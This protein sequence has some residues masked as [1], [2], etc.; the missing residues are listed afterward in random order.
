MALPERIGKYPVLRE[1]GAGA[2]S[3]VY[4]AR[5]PFAG[6]EVAIKVFLFDKHADEHEERMMHKAFVAEA[7][8]AGK[9]NHP[10]IVDIFDAVVDPDRSYLVMEYVAGT[11]L[12]AH[13]EAP[14]LLP[15]GKV[16]EII[17][18]CV[19]ALE[20]A[21]RHGVIHRD[22][23]PGN[24]L[25]SASGETK[26]G[27]FGASFQQKLLDTTQVSLVGSPAYMS[28]EQIRMEPLT[29]QTDIYSLGVTMYRLVTGRLP[30]AA[31]TQA[32]LTYAI[33]NAEP[34]RP[35]QLRPEL[36]ALLDSVVMRAIAKDPAARYASW[37][38]FGRDLSQAFAALRQA[39]GVLSD[40]ERF[41][42]LR[43][44]PF[45]ADFNDVAL[46]E[47]VRIGAWK[48]IAAGSVVLREGEPGD[49][50]Y[51]LADGEVDVTLSG[52]LL[53]TVKAGRCFG[54]ML[55]FSEHEQPRSTTVSAR[56]DI[57]V[58]EVKAAAMR[59]A[60]DACQA[61]LNRACMRVLIERLAESNR[62]LAQ[63]A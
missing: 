48:T 33:L 43:E 34:Q 35:A 32:G 44:S 19:R 42:K 28:P 49:A 50:L 36:P 6:R 37:L 7:S 8:L 18:K 31:S 24:I 23:K 40:S 51:F 29:H 38:D 53:A 60:S 4:L 58:L 46:W 12:E 3:K 57:G 17:F 62:R 54:E 22:I 56:R 9:L 27:D 45:F 14:T 5:D 16:V 41:N 2:T 10:H 21:C 39:G 13:A 11:T 61:A 47:L 52:K 59:A 26:V 20:Y 55:Y 15:L 25:L 30:F 63:A 1:I